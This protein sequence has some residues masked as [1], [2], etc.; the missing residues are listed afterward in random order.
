MSSP[1]AA[2]SR[3]NAL[4]VVWKT[5]A[6][7]LRGRYRIAAYEPLSRV[8]SGRPATKA[9]SARIPSASRVSKGVHLHQLLPIE[10]DE[11]MCVPLWQVKV[12]FA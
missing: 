3:K 2:Q 8:P 9:A 5:L 6:A 10:P 4:L 1:P 12:E 7:R 11:P